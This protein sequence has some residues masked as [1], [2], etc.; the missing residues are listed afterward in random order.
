MHLE[1]AIPSREVKENRL[2]CQFELERFKGL[3][4]LGIH[5]NAPLGVTFVLNILSS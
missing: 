1:R 4:L 5:D 2:G 3:V